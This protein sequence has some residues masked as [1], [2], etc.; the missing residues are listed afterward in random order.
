MIT[1]VIIVKAV[2]TCPACPSQWDAWDL[3]GHYWYLRYR[4]GRGTAERQP[5]PDIATWVDRAP[6]VAFDGLAAGMAD[7]W[8]ELADFARLA[9][10]TIAPDAELVAWQDQ[11]DEVGAL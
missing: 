7:G 2:E 11:G 4:H 5:D 6:A 9:G 1:E 8:I 3:D 10:L